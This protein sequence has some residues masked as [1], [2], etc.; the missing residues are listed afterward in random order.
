MRRGK[1]GSTID[2][3]LCLVMRLALLF[4]QQAYQLFGI[5][6]DRSGN[7]L[8]RK[9]AVLDRGGAPAFERPPCCGHGSV[10]LFC[11]A[12]RNPGDN[13]L[14]C[15]IDDS[16]TLFSG[17]QLSI[18]EVAINLGHVRLSRFSSATYLRHIVPRVTV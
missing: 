10:E 14:R 15:R 11:A 13:L 7:F 12:C 4:G 3:L 8:D 9:T 17:N 1:T 18:D 16:E 6:L 2:F 5:V